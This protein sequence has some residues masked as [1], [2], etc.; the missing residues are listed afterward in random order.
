MGKLPSLEHVK[1][2]KRRG[3]VYAYFNTGRKSGGKV[4]YTPLPNPASP[5]FYTQY[6]NLKSRRNNRQAKGYTVADLVDEYLKSAEYAKK[7]A[8]TQKLYRI[9][10]KKINEAWGKFPVNEL[11][12][13]HVRFVLEGAGWGAGTHNAVVAML[14]AV[15]TWGRKRA[16]TTREPV[17]AEPVKDIERAD[18][19]THEP[20]PEDVLEAALS[21]DDATVRLAVHLLYF[22]GQRISDV[23]AMRWGDIRDNVLT[24]TP[25]KTQRFK[26]T[27]QITIHAELRAELDRTPRTG[28]T[29]LHGFNDYQLRGILQAFTRDLGVETVPHGLRKNAVNALLEAGCTIAEVAAITGQTFQIVEHYAARVNTKQLGQAAMLKFEGKRR[30]TV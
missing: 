13:E 26:K 2:V 23:L 8:A 10:A 3:K 1:F 11:A 12:P 18:I 17:T 24:V 22:T 29:I 9:Q 14:G 6:G 7:A 20:W 16:K 28:L 4:I 27:L 15:Y 30:K 19:G 21:S 5:E 25:K